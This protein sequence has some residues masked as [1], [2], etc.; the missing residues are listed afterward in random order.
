MDN[1]K[2]E[3]RAEFLNSFKSLQQRFDDSLKAAKEDEAR[4]RRECEKFQS[5]VNKQL[6]TAKNKLAKNNPLSKQLIAFSE[7]IEST[8]NDWQNRIDKQDTGVRF[9]EGFNDSLMVFVYG[10]VKSGKSSLGNYMAWGNTDPD[11]E[12][13]AQTPDSVQPVYFSGER[14]EVKGGDALKE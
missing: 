9:R 7:V 2:I 6:T 14:T 5:N 8:N 3:R 12:L 1:N 13:K 4:F 10:K 11:S